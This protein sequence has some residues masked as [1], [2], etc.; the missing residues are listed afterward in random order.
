MD[1]GVAP[2][3]RGS[4]RYQ[5]RKARRMGVDPHDVPINP[6]A[7]S[8]QPPEPIGESPVSDLAYSLSMT[9][10]LVVL[11]ICGGFV[12]MASGIDGVWFWAWV[13]FLLVGQWILWNRRKAGG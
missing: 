1:Q 11:M 12:M 6:R 7:G 13:L 9:A 3:S 2:R 5:R 8:W 10:L 4:L